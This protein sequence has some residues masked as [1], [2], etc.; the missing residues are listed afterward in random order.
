MKVIMVIWYITDI[1]H[2]HNLGDAPFV[3]NI[4]VYT[5][6]NLVDTPKN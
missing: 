1:I 4:E 2:T 3:Q 6:L 5:L